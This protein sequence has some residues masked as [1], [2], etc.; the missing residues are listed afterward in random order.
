MRKL[1]GIALVGVLML[2]ASCGSKTPLTEAQSDYAG[3]WVSS[4]G[5]WLQIY[6]NGGGDFKKSNA[7]V[8]GGFTAITEGTITIGELGIDTE[9]KIDVAPYQEDGE[10]YMELDGYLYYKQ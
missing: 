8:T 1:L 9:Y 3:K 6:N 4:D 10:W 2:F 5:T 7:S